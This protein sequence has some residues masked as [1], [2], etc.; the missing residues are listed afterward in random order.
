VRVVAAT[1]VNFLDSVEKV[2]FGKICTT[3]LNTVPIYVPALRER[4]S[5]IELLFRKFAVDFAEKYKVQPFTLP[6]M[7]K[8]ACA[9]YRFPG[10]IRQL[11]NLVEQM[12]VLR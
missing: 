7:Q 2:S 10:N 9:K 5:D 1:N 8:S 11:K 6:K 12:S 4:G 3:G